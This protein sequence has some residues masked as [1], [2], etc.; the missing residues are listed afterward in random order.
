MVAPL[1]EKGELPTIDY[2]LMICDGYISPTPPSQRIPLQKDSLMGAMGS[3]L[4]NI[5]LQLLICI[6]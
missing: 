3:M 1:G 2:H 6:A 5:H 4:C